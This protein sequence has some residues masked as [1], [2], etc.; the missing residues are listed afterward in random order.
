M[1]LNSY[2]VL[3]E[4]YIES[5][6]DGEVKGYERSLDLESSLVK[7][8]YTQNGINFEREYFVSYPDNCMMIKLKS[9]ESVKYKLYGGHIGKSHTTAGDEV[10]YF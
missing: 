9:S 10:L 7:T 2:L 1:W 6:T 3:G 5:L 4:L 8:S